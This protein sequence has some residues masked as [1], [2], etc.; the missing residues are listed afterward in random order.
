[1][2][3]VMDVVRKKDIQVELESALMRHEFSL[4]IEEDWCWTDSFEA[5][6]FRNLEPKMKTV[7]ALMCARK[8]ADDAMEMTVDEFIENFG[9]LFDEFDLEGEE[10]EIT[11][12][13]GEEEKEERIRTEQL[14][15]HYIKELKRVH[16]LYW[17]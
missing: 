15:E 6:V 10:E 4:I 3:K 14:G 16:E 1:M 7:Y 2:L 13:E 11:E 17:G 9:D 8:F 12:K 5:I